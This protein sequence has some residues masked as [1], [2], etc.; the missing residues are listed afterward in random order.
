[1]KKTT[2]T[3]ALAAIVAMSNAQALQMNAF[4][5]VGVGVEAG[6]M[7]AGVEVAVPVVTNHL[8]LVAGV[9]FPKVTFSTD[10]TLNTGDWNDKIGELNQKVDKLNA[11][12][13]QPEYAQYQHPHYDHV[14]YLDP[15]G[16]MT[17]TAD[18]EI[19]LPAFKTM[20]EYYPSERS[21]FHFVAGVMIGKGDFISIHGEPDAVSKNAYMSALRLND[22]IQNDPVAQKNDI[23]GIKDIGDVLHFNIDDKTYRVREDCSLDAAI[24]I[25]KVRPYAGIGFGRSVPNKRV[26]FQFEMGAWF[27]GTPKVVSP[28]ELPADKYDPNAESIEGVGDIIS[29]ITVYPQITF[30]LTGRIL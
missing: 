3:L 23:Q 8:V 30:R 11:K 20:L 26:G 7:G 6:L 18:A 15:S 24:Q 19:N 25:S 13:S 12:Y 4:R 27:H 9:T 29:K 10:I 16:E 2:L 5:N 1:M 21:T 22:A 14:E 28:N 17:V